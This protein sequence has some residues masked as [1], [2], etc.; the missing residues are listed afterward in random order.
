MYACRI[1]EIAR[2]FR[3][4]QRGVDGSIRV[5]ARDVRKNAL[6]TAALIQIVVDESDAQPFTGYGVELLYRGLVR[7]V[8]PARLSVRPNIERRRAAGRSQSLE[9]MAFMIVAT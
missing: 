3:V 5:C 4:Q 6:G 9:L 8:E 7:A 1:D 2:L